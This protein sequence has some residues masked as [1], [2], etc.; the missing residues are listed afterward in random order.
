MFWNSINY[1]FLLFLK[2]DN[3]QYSVR[4]PFSVVSIIREPAFCPVT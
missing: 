3:K 4:M 2:R 1:S